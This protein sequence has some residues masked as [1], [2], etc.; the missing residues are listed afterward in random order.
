MPVYRSAWNGTIPVSLLAVALASL[1]LADAAWAA[2]DEDAQWIEVLSPNFRVVSDADEDDARGIAREFEV[3]RSVFLRALPD[4]SAESRRP[5]TILAVRDEDGL[6]SLMPQFQDRGTRPTGAFLEG[7]L[8][9]HIVLRVDIGEYDDFRT[10]YHEYFPS[11][12]SLNARRLPTWLME[13]LAE[14][15]SNTAVHRATAE[16]GNSRLDHLDFLARNKLLPLETLLT[17]DSDPHDRDV[18]GATLFYAQSWALTHLLL[19]GDGSGVS[20]ALQDYISR[21]QAGENAVTAFEAAV[22]PLADVQRTLGGY[23]RQPAYYAIRMD[24]PPGV[25]E[26]AFSIRTLSTAKSLVARAR[27]LSQ[28][29]HAQMAQQ[30]LAAALAGPGL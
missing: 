8:E 5:L 29:G 25:D 2:Q 12:T 7:S 15:Y 11:L 14:V 1:V 30:M 23:V 22:G 28:G 13:G 24:A 3:I 27:F 26:S 16:I 9:H 17:D 19:L 4:L 21:V 6:I 18:Y 20:I 10:I